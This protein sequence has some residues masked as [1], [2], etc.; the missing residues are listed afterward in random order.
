MIINGINVEVVRKRIKNINLSVSSPDGRVRVSAPLGAAER[1]IEQFV[2]SKMHWI[3]KQITKMAAKKTKQADYHYLS[4]E[5]HLLWGKMHPVIFKIGRA[6]SCAAANADTI[7]LSESA[8]P[9][10]EKRKEIINNFYRRQLK[11]KAL[12]LIL[13]WSGAIGVEPKGWS[14]K[15]MTTRWGTCNTKTKHIWIN[16]QLAKMPVEC[17][18]YIV[19]HEL[20]HLVI[21]NHSA[22]FK[23]LMSRYLPQ[24]KLARKILKEF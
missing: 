21:G 13:H 8:S 5:E 23:A 11:E 16:L 18:E 22:A 12:P 6:D 17:L 19:V 24:W 4:G 14:V 7:V 9:T 15:N 3:D 20:C 10:A 2:T 1:I